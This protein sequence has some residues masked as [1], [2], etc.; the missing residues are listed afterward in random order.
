M[1][2]PVHTES[3]RIEEKSMSI[4][5]RVKS[6]LL[7]PKATWPTIDAESASVQSVYVPYVVA[8]AAIS[9]VAG[10][11]GTSIVGVGGFGLSYRVPMVSG[12]LNMVVGFVLALVMVFVMALIADALAP[13]FGG[14][15]NQ[16]SAL[17]LIGYGSTAGFLGGVFSIIPAASLLGLLAA[18]YSIYLIYTGVPVLMKCPK[19]KALGYTAVL[20]VCGIVAGVILASVSVMFGGGMRHGMDIGGMGAGG[21][22][23]T[24]EVAIKTP[25]GEIKI[26][27]AKLE[28]MAKKMEAAGK[29]AD[30]AQQS[31]DP[32]AAV[33]AATGMMAAMTG[34][35][36]RPVMPVAD[37]KALLPESLGSM[38][39][40]S[41][42]AE[43]NSAMGLNVASAKARYGSESK[44]VRLSITDTGGLAAV[45]AGWANVTGER[46]DDRKIEKTYKQGSR[47]V[48]EEYRKDGS[49]G[50]YT[51]L[52]ANGVVVEAEGG[53]VQVGELKA[54]AESLDLSRV[55]AL[56]A[57]AK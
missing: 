48:H 26:D 53:P 51:V 15:K 14:Q 49:Q 29:E 20:V 23:P 54:A 47:T 41:F 38:K 3:A 34:G 40:Q 35:A 16:I 33:K 28:D 50:Q 2:R 44:Q 43:S 56:K 32:A 18:L 13:A 45:V 4:V 22:R 36:Q 57:P 10:F 12:L 11:I 5:Q 21:A 52:L 1:V 17:K 31:G 37:L 30:A 8:L 19:D 6:L 39:R 25:G 46:E 42:E 7:D 55:E 27:T 9:A 24:P